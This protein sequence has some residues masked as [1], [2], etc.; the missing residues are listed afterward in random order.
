VPGPKSEKRYI[1]IE[2]PTTLMPCGLLFE[3]FIDVYT[4]IEGTEPT[5]GRKK[6]RAGREKAGRKTPVEVARI[7]CH[8]LF[9]VE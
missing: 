5:R 7:K 4:I 2:V 1:L 9:S 8:G 3:R 6:E